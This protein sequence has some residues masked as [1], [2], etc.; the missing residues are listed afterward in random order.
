MIFFFSGTYQCTFRKAS[1]APKAQ[2]CLGFS[3]KRISMKKLVS[4]RRMLTP[5]KGVIVK[6]FAN[7]KRKNTGV[8][9]VRAHRNGFAFSR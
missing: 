4:G 6:K 8:H 2:K 1:I 7:V 5:V 9:G 3:S